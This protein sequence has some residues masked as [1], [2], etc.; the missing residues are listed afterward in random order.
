[1]QWG[2][3][4]DALFMYQLATH[5][6]FSKIKVAEYTLYIRHSVLCLA[7]FLW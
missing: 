2:K 7:K 3:K 5:T 1:M 6:E 4:H